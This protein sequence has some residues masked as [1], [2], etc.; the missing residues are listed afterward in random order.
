M[1][2]LMMTTALATAMAV[3]ALAQET[4]S[5][6]TE[7]AAGDHYGSDLIG[8]RLYVSEAEVDA[9]AD[10]NSEARAE[11]EDVGEINDILIG[12]DG[13]VKAV[14]L[15]IG[16][17]LGIGEKRV[18]VDMDELQFVTEGNGGD[19]YF[20]VIQ[21]TSTMLE[22]AP[23]FDMSAEVSEAANDV[24][25]MAEDAAGDVEMAAEEAGDAAADATEE[26]AEETGE[27]AEDAEMAAEEL[28][29]DA[30]EALEDA[31]ET[32]E[33]AAETAAEGVENAAEDVAE[34]ADAMADEV[35]EEMAEGE[36]A[37]EGLMVEDEAPA[38]DMAAD[39]SEDGAVATETGEGM[40]S[41]PSMWDAPNVQRDG[42]ENVEMVDLTADM[43]TGTTVYGPDQENVG[44][45]SD[46]VL[47]E[48]GSIDK[49]IV[50]VGGFLGI[51]EHR[52]AID[53]DELQVIR[54]PDYGSVEVHVGATQEQLEERPEYDG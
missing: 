31:A 12:E 47:A 39:T 41:A 15:D 8:Q 28:A 30:G 44:E 27:A 11:W 35:S 32:T 2:R 6:V 19:D 1:R 37:E 18:A 46:L 53:F 45:V 40:A 14:L 5:F 42:F 17:F 13:S 9:E 22:D 48:D 25:N 54:D 16:G 24:E 50:D 36:A 43:V 26:V 33:A 21:G 51:G 10:W 52:I 4:E 34:G 38:E 3:P 20:V 23:E 7:I 29:D 49:A